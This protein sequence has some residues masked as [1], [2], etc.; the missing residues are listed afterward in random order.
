M[1][2]TVLLFLLVS[3]FF[4]L[5]AQT[6][7]LPR[8]S[9]EKEKVSAAGLAAFYKAAEESDLKFHSA[10]IVRNGCVVAEKWWGDN[11]P[12]KPHVM[13][14]VSKSFTATAVGFAISEGLL[15]LDDKVI[16][17]FPDK[18][19]KEVSP[20]LKNLKISDLL[21]MSVGQATEG[22]IRTQSDWIKAFFE[23][24]IVR[25]PGA[26]FYYNSIATFMLSAIVQK[27]SGQKIFDYLT[28]RLFEPLNIK[29]IYWEENPQGINTG[30]WG[31][32]IKTEDMAKFGQLFLQLG[33]W[34]GKQILP[35][36]WVEQA[37]TA[38]IKS[39]P[40]GASEEGDYSDN[41]W[42]QGYCYQMWR[43]K[44]N[45]YRADGASGQFIFVF[46][47]KNAVVAITA[48][49]NNMDK[50]IK[51]VWEHILPALQ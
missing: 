40:A 7:A 1:K 3:L 25:E 42:G 30:G 6:G 16:S 37:S 13:H 38:K 49:M 29:D 21:T 45:A 24:P 32:Y 11:A 15:K 36:G 34:N 35:A 33:K 10:M 43:C 9:P 18:L 39:R 2:H 4:R 50:G 27:V 41:E 28:P 12:D 5:P 22:D 48:G 31:L 51:L 8:T 46:P 47:E 14:S 19:P 44:H 20:Y 17:F 23:N 26:V